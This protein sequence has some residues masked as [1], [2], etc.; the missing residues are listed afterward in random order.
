MQ[1]RPGQAEARKLADMSDDKPTTGAGL[2][3]Q[4][5]HP[6]KGIPTHRHDVPVY[7]ATDVD[8]ALAAKDADVEA[9]RKTSDGYAASLK[10]AYAALAAKDAEIARLLRDKAGLMEDVQQFN[11]EIDSISGD[12]A[13]LQPL[14]AIGRLAVE[15][16]EREEK[17]NKYKIGVF[18]ASR[19][20]ESYL[21]DSMLN[22]ID[23]YRAAQP[24]QDGEGAK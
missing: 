18:S 8:A 23:A 19:H 1:P 11:I 3:K 21:R 13:A 15:W 16:R 9:W 4:W 22:A 10:M 20:T 24:E 5:A 14:A 7:L 2:E 17:N 6:V 12:V